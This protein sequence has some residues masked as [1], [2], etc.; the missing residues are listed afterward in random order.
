M[1][2]S[3]LWRAAIGLPLHAS[4]TNACAQVSI[5]SSDV[6][7]EIASTALSIYLFHVE[8]VQADEYPQIVQPMVR[9]LQQQLGGVWDVY[10][11]A[12]AFTYSIHCLGFVELAGE[13]W[14]ALLCRQ[15]LQS[16]SMTPCDAL[17]LSSNGSLAQSHYLATLQSRGFIQPPQAL[18]GLTLAGHH[19]YGQNLL[20]SAGGQAQQEAAII[21]DQVASIRAA[22]IF[23][24]LA[25]SLRASLEAR[26]GQVPC[27]LA[28]M[29]GKEHVTAHACRWGV[30]IETE[31][32][33][34]LTISS[35]ET[36]QFTERHGLV[37]VVHRR[38]CKL[39]RS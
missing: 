26:F 10:S 15:S 34:L 22:D 29:Q 9:D 32:A 23:P 5:A 16:S 30:V 20:G 1:L 7:A 31:P 39:D 17:Q 3:L 6:S 4:T 18:D 35:E 2:Y 14:H 12:N 25:H 24:S 11:T 8:P 28:T 27:H 13:Q 38:L 19:V 36:L 33:G 21:R 37:I